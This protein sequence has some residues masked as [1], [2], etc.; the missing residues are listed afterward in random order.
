MVAYCVS[1]AENRGEPARS[2]YYV[3]A[4]TRVIH[5]CFRITKSGWAARKG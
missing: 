4:S 2:G 5:N 3:I 1:I